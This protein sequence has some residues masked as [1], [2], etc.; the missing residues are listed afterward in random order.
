MGCAE[1]K[2]QDPGSPGFVSPYSSAASPPQR[3]A[4]PAVACPPQGCTPAPLPPQPGGG[5][6]IEV[7]VKQLNGRSS[8]VRV[9]SATTVAGFK[10][11]IGEQLGLP[12]PQMR[13]VFAGRQLDDAQLLATY[14]VT[15]GATVHLVLRMPKGG[16]QA[17]QRKPGLQ[18]LLDTYEVSVAAAADLEVLARY[19]IVFLV[20]DSGSMNQVEVTNGVRQTR[21]QE[22]K[23]TLAALIEFATYFDD[24]GTDVHFLNRASVEGVT[25]SKDPRLVQAFAT[26]PSGRTPLSS[27]FRDVVSKHAGGAKPLLVVIATD[28]EPD[29]GAAD[30]IQTARQLMGGRTD[31]RLAVM[32]CTQDQRAVRWLNSLDDDPVVGDKVD[33]CDDYESERAEVLA[34]G[35]VRQFLVSDYYVKALLGPILSKYD[36]FD[37]R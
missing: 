25:D 36:N 18:D 11:A 31:V 29:T 15:E 10:Q 12:P 33:V 7:Q 17:S 8:A 4:P 28:G 9:D 26:R 19:D 24:D 6:L 21:W 5:A 14:G 13:L 1:S 23:D 30:F 27:R 2:K 32:A 37:Q 22:V 20:D 3:A 34:T 16:A 35:K